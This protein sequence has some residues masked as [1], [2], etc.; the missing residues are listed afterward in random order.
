MFATRSC[1][2][3]VNFSSSHVSQSHGYL[4]HFFCSLLFFPRQRRVE[5]VVGHENADRWAHKKWFQKTRIHLGPTLTKRPARC[6]SLAGGFHG[7]KS[8]QG[9]WTV[10]SD[11]RRPN[12]THCARSGPSGGGKLECTVQEQRVMAPTNSF[13]SRDR[14]A[15]RYRVS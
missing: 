5:S 3:C 10:F 6:N 13:R 1:V 7:M 2:N 15:H 11:K 8:D 14:N 4:L 9:E 12:G